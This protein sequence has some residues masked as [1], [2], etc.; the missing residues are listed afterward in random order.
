MTC[1][2]DKKIPGRPSTPLKPLSPLSPGIP[3]IFFFIIIRNQLNIKL[4]NKIIKI[5][6]IPGSPGLPLQP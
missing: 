6:S 1:Y 3:E 2:T 4:N 5:P